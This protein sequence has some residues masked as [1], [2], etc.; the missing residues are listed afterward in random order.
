[1]D[2]PVDFKRLLLG[3]PHSALDHA[4]VAFAAE[5][6]ELMGLGVLGLF[7]E[8]EGLAHL[9]ALPQARELRS[10]GGG[11]HPIDAAE[12]AAIRGQAAVE[13]RRRFEEAAKTRRVAATFNRAEGPIAEIIG[14][15]STAGDIIVVIEPRNPAERVTHQFMQLMDAAFNAPSAVLLVPSRITRRSG[16]IVA[17]AE[18]AEDASVQAALKLAALTKERLIVL[19]PPKLDDRELARLAEQSGVAVDRQALPGK[20]GELELSALLSRNRERFVVLSRE[21]ADD[22]RPARLASGRRV[23]VLVTA[24]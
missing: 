23:P 3:L 13:A 17:V 16:P 9:A 11:W 22:R 1:M 19:A 21:G 18:S 5:L 6:A 2:S 12:L 8:D 14:S 20:I 4:S 10:L 7:M 15:Q 24:E